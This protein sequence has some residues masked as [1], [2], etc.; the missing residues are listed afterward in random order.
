MDR[1]EIKL[2]A[3]E[4]AH[5]KLKDFW[6]GFGIVFAVSFLINLAINLLF[7]D[8]SLFGAAVSMVASFFLATL[9]VGLLSYTLNIVRK[10]K[11]SRDDIFKYVNKILPIVAISLL[12]VVLCFLWSILLIIPGII[13]AIGY[14]FVYYCYIDDEDL[15]PSEC[16]SK[17]KEMLNGYKWDYFVF[18]LSFIGWMFLCIFIIPL[19]WIVPYVSMA[20]SIYY[21]ELK[22]VQEKK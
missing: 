14:S 12:T 15:T 16:L 22:K 13:A 21:D 7:D 17:S 2:K 3:K 10:K 8:N 20:Q 1:K 6:K 4:L 19:I 18:N 11:Y 9:E 5:E